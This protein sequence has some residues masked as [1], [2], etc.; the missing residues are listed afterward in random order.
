MTTG[1]E[2][3]TGVKSSHLR[4]SSAMT[5]SRPR[6]SLAS[7]KPGWVIPREDESGGRPRPGRATSVLEDPVSPKFVLLTQYIPQQRRQSVAR[8]PGSIWRTM[9]LLWSLSFTGIVLAGNRVCVPF[10]G[11]EATWQSTHF[12]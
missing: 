4:R 1:Q 10:D 6:S 8:E 7:P 11:A 5:G 12:G 3:C 2:E 9:A